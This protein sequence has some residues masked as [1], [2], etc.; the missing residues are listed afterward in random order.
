MKRDSRALGI[1]AIEALPA[2]VH[3]IAPRLYL[4]REE[5]PSGTK[6]SVLVRWSQDGKA[7]VKSLGPW[8]ADRY[9]HFLAEAGRADEAQREGRDVRVVLDEGVAPDT[10]KAA[11]EGYMAKN[12]PA[13]RDQ[14]HAKR[15]RKLMESTYPVL[16]H[17]RITQL[18]AGH[19]AKTLGDDWLRTPVQSMR[20]RRR[21]EHVIDFGIAR[22]NLQ[23][24][25]VARWGVMRHRLDK[26]PRRQV[27]HMR[28]LPYARVPALFK[29]LG[30][31]RLYSSEALRFV[32]LTASRSTEVRTMK[33]H[34]IDFENAV[35]TCPAAR[36]KLHKDHRVPLPPAALALLA[37]MKAKRTSDYVFPGRKA[38]KPVSKNVLGNAMKRVGFDD[39]V[40]HG[41]RSTFK[42]WA[43]ETQTFNWEAVELCLAHEVGSDVERAYGRSD[44]LHLRRPIMQ[45]W[46]D[47]VRRLRPEAEL[48][49]RKMAA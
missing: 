47:F 11:A 41:M 33:W 46:A 35:W 42:D 49:T 48:S 39:G 28:A 2:G 13:L 25:N 34:E 14:K 43:R 4:K 10:F 32:I 30:A 26:Q 7:Q 18:E 40:P 45:A 1:K 20:L 6:R 22:G 44:L 21:I 17:L 31:E 3:K 36:M 38:G 23:I 24:S 27:K 5:R 29:A 9:G 8:S 16:G 37:D 19:I 15:W 12:L